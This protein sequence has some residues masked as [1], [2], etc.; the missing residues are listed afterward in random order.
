MNIDLEYLGD[1]GSEALAERFSV[2]PPASLID[3]PAERIDQLA[4]SETARKKVEAFRAGGE[5]PGRQELLKNV[6]DF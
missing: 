2:A 1:M 5:S 6:A 3:A 4:Q